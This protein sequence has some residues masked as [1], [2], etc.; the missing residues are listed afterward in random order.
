[1]AK[2][3]RWPSTPPPPSATPA[4][5]TSPGSIIA[6]NKTSTSSSTTVRI[7]DTVSSATVSSSSLAPPARSP[8]SADFPAPPGST[9][10]TD[11]RHVGQLPR[12]SS[13][14]HARRLV[15]ERV[16]AR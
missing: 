10:G 15:V 12:I 3:T 16:P 7:S 5:S 11:A 1:M 2:P 14:A 9:L 8:G 4:L 13:H 6:E